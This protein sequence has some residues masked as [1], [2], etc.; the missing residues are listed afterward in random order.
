ML[1]TVYSAGLFGIDGFIVS[2]ECNARRDFSDFRLVGLPDLAVK[3]AQERVRTA[4]DNSG[5]KFPAM[6]LM[7]NLAPADRRKEGSGFDVAILLGILRSGGYLNPELDLSKKC[8]VGE[9]S[10]S[11]K[12]RGQHN[13]LVVAARGIHRNVAVDDHLRSV[14]KSGFGAAAR[15][16]TCEHHPIF[17][18]TGAGGLL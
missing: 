6:A 17:F 8:F 9:L 7:I 3:E 13:Q 16:R 18:I 14:P 15:Q 4:C 1:S 12:L 10:L 11:G 2:A 5:F